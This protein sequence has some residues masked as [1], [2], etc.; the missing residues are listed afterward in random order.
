VVIEFAVR[1][2]NGGATLYGSQNSTELRKL[3]RVTQASARLR[4][5][6]LMDLSPDPILRENLKPTYDVQSSGPGNF[7]RHSVRVVYVHSTSRYN[8]LWQPN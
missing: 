1:P 3:C 4:V 2:P 6:L 5:L 8:F 7:I